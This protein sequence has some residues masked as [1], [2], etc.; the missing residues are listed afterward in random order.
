MTG[1]LDEGVNEQEI[2]SAFSRMDRSACS[3]ARHQK[4]AD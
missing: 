3:A 4:D 1:E 2:L